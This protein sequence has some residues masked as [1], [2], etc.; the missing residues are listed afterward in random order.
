MMLSIDIL[1]NIMLFI[2]I[3]ENIG[4]TSHTNFVLDMQN[5]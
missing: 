1:E 3:L 5:V 4:W 2:D